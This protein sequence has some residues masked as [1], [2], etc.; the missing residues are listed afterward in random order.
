M[1]PA[2]YPLF[3]VNTNTQVS[4]ENIKN[5]FDSGYINEGQ[6]VVELQHHLEQFFETSNLVLTNSGTSA[7]TLALKICGVGPGDEVLTTAMTCIATNTPIINLGAH[8]VWVDIE[9]SS[10]SISPTDI[11]KKISDKTKAILIVDWA[12]T[13]CNLDEII[14]IGKKYSLKIIQDAAHAFGAKWD[15]K[16]ISDWTDFTCYSFQAI[17]H[18][19]TGDGGALVVKDISDFNLAKKLKWFGFD[20]DK[21][22][23]EKGNW[24]G[25]KWDADIELNEVGFKFNMNNISAAIGLANLSSI[26]E[27][28]KKHRENAS[29]YSRIFQDFTEIQPLTVPIKA[30]SSYWVFTVL[31][32]GKENTRDWI[33]E[34]L[35]KEG[36]GAGLVHLPNHNYSCFQNSY[37]HLEETDIFSKTQ[38]SLP[39]GWWLEKEDI[40]FI[41]NALIRLTLRSK[42]C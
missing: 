35:N 41:A 18:F 2:K 19:T 10:G 7:I 23:D 5:V 26:N 6:Q 9:A 30:T 20:R 16:S 12:G 38:I 21:V 24:K 31:V 15:G 28:L 33:L 17:K 8:P 4:L 32:N 3:K 1:I 11:E 34:E 13:P 37:T 42:S 22:K 27:T 14:R 36:I 29:F 25:Q 39:C 40:E